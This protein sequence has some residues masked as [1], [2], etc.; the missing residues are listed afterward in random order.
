[1]GNGHNLNH[2]L[3]ASPAQPYQLL[4]HLSLAYPT[5]LFF[6]ILILILMK[7]INM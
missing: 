3:V 4:S 5:L 1:M 2:I 7:S 6:C